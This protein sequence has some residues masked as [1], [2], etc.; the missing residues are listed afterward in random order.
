MRALA[1]RPDT[2]FIRDDMDGQSDD[3]LRALW[4][5]GR[6]FAGLFVFL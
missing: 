3:G 2:Y 1:G 5:A 4:S 6:T